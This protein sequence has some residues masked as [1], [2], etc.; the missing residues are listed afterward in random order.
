M[1]KKARRKIKFTRPITETSFTQQLTGNSKFAL[2]LETGFAEA[3]HGLKEAFEGL[4]AYVHEDRPMSPL[5]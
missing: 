1:S 3:T 5:N 2:S 4:D